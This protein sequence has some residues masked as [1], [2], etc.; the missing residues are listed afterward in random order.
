MTDMD[1][2]T[3]LG[4]NGFDDESEKLHNVKEVAAFIHTHDCGHIAEADGTPF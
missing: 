2:D 4:H 1:Y 3:L